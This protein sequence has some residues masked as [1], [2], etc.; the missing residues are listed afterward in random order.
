MIEPTAFIGCDPGAT[1]Y[2]CLVVPS[3]KYVEFYPNNTKPREIA[4]WLSVQKKKYSIAIVMIEDVHTLFGMSAKSNFTFGRNVEKI[5]VIPSIV[6]LSIDLV[7]PKVWQRFI[8]IKAKSKTIKQDVAVIC[9]RLYPDVNIRGPKGGLKDGKS[10][11][12]MLAHYASQ[13]FIV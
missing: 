7:Q 1:G 13:T 3:T 5:N 11:A 8:G 9:E 10:D 6:G 4:Q 2:Y 12:L